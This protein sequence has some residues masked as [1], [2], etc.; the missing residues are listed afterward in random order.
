MAAILHR[1]GLMVAVLVAAVVILEL[2]SASGYD[3]FVIPFLGGV[4]LTATA[5]GG[6]GSR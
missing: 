2:M 4:M 1:V 3:W 5:K 6:S